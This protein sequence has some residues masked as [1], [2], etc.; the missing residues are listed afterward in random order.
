MNISSR[1]W[2][3]YSLLLLLTVIWGSSFILYKE[4]LKVLDWDQVA[5]LRI[6]IAASCFLPMAI[7]WWKRVDKRALPSIIA[8]RDQRLRDSSFF[9]C[10]CTNRTGIG[11]NRHI[12][13]TYSALYFALRHSVF[14]I[15]D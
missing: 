6:L 13:H 1:S 2:V 15:T 14:Q 4:G 7:Y 8:G 9:I 12:E 5:L 10:H 11:F 3:D